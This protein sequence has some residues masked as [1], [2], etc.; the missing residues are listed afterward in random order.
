MDTAIEILAITALALLAANQ[1]KR[2]FDTL[3][4]GGKHVADNTAHKCADGV[5][6]YDVAPAQNNNGRHND[7]NQP[8]TV[9]HRKPRRTV[10][11]IN[12]AKNTINYGFG[13]FNT[14][15]S[16]ALAHGVAALLGTIILIHK[17]RN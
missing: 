12:G 5:L 11:P 17:L 9:R 6:T 3:F 2:L 10:E 13:E 1:G 14:V 8:H 15:G 4:K 7:E 16:F